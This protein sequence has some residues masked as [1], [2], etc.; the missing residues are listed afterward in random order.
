[1]GQ[2]EPTNPLYIQFAKEVHDTFMRDATLSAG[3]EKHWKNLEAQKAKFAND[4]FK[5][6]EIQ[7]KQE[8]IQEEENAGGIGFKSLFE[9]YN[10][11]TRAIQRINKVNAGNFVTWQDYLLNE[12][13]V[14]QY[15]HENKV[16]VQDPVSV[17]NFYERQRQD[18]ARVILHTIKS[19]ENKFSKDVGQ[20]IKLEDIKPYG[21]GIGKD[22]DVTDSEPY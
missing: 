15:L 16:N 8:R 10:I 12:G 18:A 21:Q 17:K 19:V 5:L 2:P 13:E 22:V 9:R 7:A 14:M 11:A 20:P 6:S 4:P 1:M 3:G